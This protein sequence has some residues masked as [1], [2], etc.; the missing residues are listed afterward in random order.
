MSINKL[1]MIAL[2]MMLCGCGQEEVNVPKTA[3]TKAERSLYALRGADQSW[4]GTGD[5]NITFSDNL[6]AR[7]FYVVFDGSGSMNST[8]CGDGNRRISVAKNSVKEFFSVLPEETNAGLLVFDIRGINQVAPIQKVN[9]T[10]LNESV[11]NISVGGNTPLGES[12]KIAS[13]QLT[14]QAQ[15]QQGYG[16]YH[17]VVITDGESSDGDYM[18]TMVSDISANTPINIHTIGFCL[19]AS[20]ALNKEGVINYSSASNSSQLLSSLKAVL[21]ESP[22]F[23]ATEF[24]G[25]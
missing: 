23:D 15:K 12:L 7:N 24:K 19:G 10:L 3:L 2:A 22:S 6:E 8:G 11:T 14:I 1:S 4:P 13:E 9:K 25:G 20:H 17:L 21:A 5:A 18:N 16:E